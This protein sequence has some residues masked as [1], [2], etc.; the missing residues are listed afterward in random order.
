MREIGRALGDGV[1]H[2]WDTRQAC[3][4]RY[5]TILQDKAALVVIDDIWNL[6]QLEPLLVNA[7]RSRFLFTTRDDTIAN[8]VT[9][10]NFSAK[11]LKDAEARELLARNA[12]ID[13]K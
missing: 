3:E 12:G 6:Q 4:N 5:K 11:L 9:E 7:R 13:V 8:A 10:R 2:G 1:E